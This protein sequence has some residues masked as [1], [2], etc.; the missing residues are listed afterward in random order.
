MNIG[1][2]QFLPIPIYMR[3][4]IMRSGNMLVS[5]PLFERIEEKKRL[6]DS[7]RPLLRDAVKRLKDEMRILHTYHSN[8]I[9]GNTLTFSETKLVIEEGITVGGKPLKDCIEARNTAAAY[10]LIEEIAKGKKEIDHAILQQIH[11]ALTKG[12]LE[13]AGKYR[14]QN[15]RIVGAKITPPDFSKIVKLV[16][17]LITDI[18]NSKKHPIETSAF[19]HHQLAKIH[20]FIDG[21]G[22]VARL[23]TNL[24]LI[25]HGY[26]PVILKVDERSKYYRALRAADDE[27]LIPFANF[28]A[29]AVN[30]GLTHYLS[31]FGGDDTPLPLKEL[32][33]GS[34]YSHEYLSLRSRQGKLDAVKI[35]G[36]W[37]STKRVL[38]QYIKS[39]ER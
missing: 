22:R 15:V 7:K 12:I 24:Y 25:K 2:R 33:R 26:P 36:V 19:L 35:D 17:K 3:K 32:A 29:K 21:N 18:K 13:E 31:I 39:V 6:L 30:E 23:L 1:K 28:I 5:K 14:T 27:N 20:P 16:D 4:C 9:E 37:H 10:D 34:P 8:A 11:E 38:K